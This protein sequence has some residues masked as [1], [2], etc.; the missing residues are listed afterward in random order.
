MALRWRLNVQL[1]P[2]FPRSDYIYNV[3]RA[4]SMRVRDSNRNAIYIEEIKR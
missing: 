2:D 1:F 3:F 4:I